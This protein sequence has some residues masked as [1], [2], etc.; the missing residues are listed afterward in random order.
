M[1]LILI[2]AIILSFLESTLIE[3]PLVFIFLFLTTIIY[4]KNTT[5]LIVFFT[6]IVLD[7]LSVRIIGETSLFLL[8]Y[9]LIVL[10]Y[11]SKFEI[12]GYYSI[13]LFS[14]IGSLVYILIFKYENPVFISILS[15]IIAVSIY[16]FLPMKKSQELASY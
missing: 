11:R 7:I 5:L 1:L 16:K 3:V 14:F 4:P 8:V 13:L 2:F 6:G 15:G 9:F 10:L 12:K